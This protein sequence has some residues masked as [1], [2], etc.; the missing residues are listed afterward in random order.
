MKRVANIKLTPTPE[1]ADVLRRTLERVNEAFNWLAARAFETG[2]TR[3]YD[4]H[5]LCYRE[6][7]ECFELT[8]QVAIRCIA[9]VVDANK[10]GARRPGRDLRQGG[11]RSRPHSFGVPAVP[12]QHPGSIE[13][14]S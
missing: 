4:L 8:A 6:L 5:K 10:A 3:Q 1:E 2:T 13:L 12:R 7:G 11:E 9:K 14:R